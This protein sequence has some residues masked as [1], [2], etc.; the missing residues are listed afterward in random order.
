MITALEL[1]QQERDRVLD[2]LFI[3]LQDRDRAI[4]KS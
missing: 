4:T 3:T 1:L 2:Q